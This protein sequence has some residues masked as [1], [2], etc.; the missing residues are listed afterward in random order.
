LKML[1]TAS[2]DFAGV[3]GAIAGTTAL[4]CAP[5]PLPPAPPAHAARKATRNSVDAKR[6]QRFLRECCKGT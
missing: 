1:G 2:L 3:D 6:I 4:G 5:P